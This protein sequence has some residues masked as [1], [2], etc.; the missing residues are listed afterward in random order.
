MGE[1][2]SFIASMFGS[3]IIATILYT[4]IS[5][6]IRETNR[7]VDRLY[8]AISTNMSEYADVIN[9][10]DLILYNSAK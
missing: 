10:N 1:I 6:K 7:R 8:A 5:A 2:T 3:L 9:N 4:F